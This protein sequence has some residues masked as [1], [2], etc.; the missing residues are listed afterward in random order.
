MDQPEPDER[1]EVDTVVKV[2]VIAGGS[3]DSDLGQIPERGQLEHGAK[4]EIR[5]GIVV[6]VGADG[7]DRVI[8]RAADKSHFRPEAPLAFG[9]NGGGEDACP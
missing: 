1:H 4:G 6:E 7:E 3:R 9:S 2:K 8:H 5:V